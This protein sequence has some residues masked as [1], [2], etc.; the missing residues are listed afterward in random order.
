MDPSIKQ[1]LAFALTFV[2]GNWAAT[3]LGQ[4]V[5]SFSSN[6]FIG[7]TIRE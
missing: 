3:S 2:S 6:P 1:F 5:S 7:M 4:F